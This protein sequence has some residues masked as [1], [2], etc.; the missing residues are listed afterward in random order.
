MHSDVWDPSPTTSL[1]SFK[2]F[3]TFVDDCSK[4]TWFYLLKHKSDV[5]VAFKSF[6]SIICTQYNTKVQVLRS[7]NDSIYPVT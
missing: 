3:V 6:Y 5:I 2:Y 4:V 1:S 7:D